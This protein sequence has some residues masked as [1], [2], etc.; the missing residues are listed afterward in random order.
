M[1]VMTGATTFP[2]PTAEDAAMLNAVAP[3][4]ARAFVETNAAGEEVITVAW[5]DGQ[6]VVEQRDYFMNA[7]PCDS[8][9]PVTDRDYIRLWKPAGAS[10]T[11]TVRFLRNRSFQS[12]LIGYLNARVEGRRRPTLESPAERPCNDT[13]AI[14]VAV[15]T[16]SYT[17]FVDLVQYHADDIDRALA[18][19]ADIV[20]GDQ[21]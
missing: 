5:Q 6:I 3:E 13:V 21:T 2:G 16:D 15:L 10:Q 9:E 20:A 1:E 8:W 18:A 11:L 17:K 7:R 12:R 4:G 14:A 19:A